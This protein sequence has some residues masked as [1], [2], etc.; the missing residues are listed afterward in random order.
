M[1]GNA[2]YKFSTISNFVTNSKSKDI[3]VILDVGANVGDV[4][5]LMHD[6]FPDARIIAFEAVKEYFDIAAAQT[7]NTA[8]ITVYNKAVTAQHL[9]LDDCGESRRGKR[10][11]L[12]ILKGLPEAGPGWVG[13]SIVTPNDDRRASGSKIPGYEKIGQE[14]VP[15]TL[16]D[17]MEQE[18]L[19]EIDL[20]KLDC[21]GC[22]FS[23]L[24]T[25]SPSVLQR[26]RF[27]VGEYHDIGR[28][29]EIMRKKLFL[30]HKVN[31]VGQ[32]DL[33][34]I[35]AERLD[36]QSDGILLYDKSGMLVPR[37]WLGDKPIEWHVFNER[38]VL[39]RDRFWHGLRE[40]A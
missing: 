22:E 3:D 10:A 12:V 17:I 7:S 26:V 38:Y 36:G 30:T 34:C 13:G 19:D 6:Y 27:I 39:P 1:E 29:A 32:R 24:G 33:G 16:S 21:E 5:L 25:A 28:F 20:L 37:P 23:V 31:L 8:N 2:C 35:F 11:D 4:T 9:F 14:V 40:Q 15:V 18:R